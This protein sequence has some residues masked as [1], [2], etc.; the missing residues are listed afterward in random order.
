MDFVAKVLFSQRVFKTSFDTWDCGS[1]K[2]KEWWEGGV[3]IR[4]CLGL[5]QFQFVVEIKAFSGAFSYI[6]EYSGPLIFQTAN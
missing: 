2:K 6:L 4:G 1:G 5:F 3:Y